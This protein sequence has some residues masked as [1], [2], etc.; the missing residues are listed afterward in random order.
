MKLDLSSSANTLT[1][2]NVTAA[3]PGFG[4]PVIGFSITT[5]TGLIPVD[6]RLL[7]DAYLVDHA[8]TRRDPFAPTLP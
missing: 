6:G 4:L 3:N 8:Y 1:G 2:G 7:D 5:R